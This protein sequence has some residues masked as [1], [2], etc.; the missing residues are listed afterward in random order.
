MEEL[1]KGTSHESL[2][3]WHFGGSFCYQTVRLGKQIPPEHAVSSRS[4]SFVALPLDIDG[5]R[6]IVEALDTWVEGERMEGQNQLSCDFL[7]EID[8]KVQ[9]VDGI[10]RCCIGSLPNTLIFHLKRFALDYTTFQTYKINSYCE[11]PDVL[12][13]GKYTE[14]YLEK[15][16]KQDAIQQ[17]K[18][19]TD[20]KDVAEGDA[21]TDDTDAVDCTYKLRGV[22]IHEGVAGGGHY[23]SLA[24]DPQGNWVKFNDITVTSFKESDLAEETYGGSYEVT[25]QA[26][27]QVGMHHQQPLTETR[28][29][30]RNAYMLYYERVVPVV[31]DVP[32]KDDK[33]DEGEV[34]GEQDED[35]GAAGDS[36]SGEAK[37]KEAETRRS[38]EEE[39]QETSQMLERIMRGLRVASDATVGDNKKLHGLRRW[40]PDVWKE[41]ASIQ[42]KRYLFEMKFFDFLRQLAS[43]SVSTGI[44]DA[45]S[46]QDGPTPSHLTQRPVLASYVWTMLTEVVFRAG[47]AK[48]LNEWSKAVQDLVKGQGDFC[49]RML[50]KMADDRLFV[51]QRLF[52]RGSLSVRN[53]FADVI[54]F[55][56]RQLPERASL[57]CTPLKASATASSFKAADP[58][59]SDDDEDLK[60]LTTLQRYEQDGTGVLPAFLRCLESMQPDVMKNYRIMESYFQIYERLAEPATPWHLRVCT[61]RSNTIASMVHLYLGRSSKDKFLPPLPTWESNVT[62]PQMGSPDKSAILRIVQNLLKSANGEAGTAGRAE[63]RD[64]KTPDPTDEEG[65]ILIPLRSV[66]AFRQRL[67]LEEIIEEDAGSLVDLLSHMIRGEKEMTITALSSLLGACKRTRAAD[68]PV[69][70]RLFVAML[71][72]DDE[73]QTDRLGVV[74]GGE[75]NL[76]GREV[77]GLV[78][79]AAN[80]A[81]LSKNSKRRSTR[82]NYDQIYPHGMSGTGRGLKNASTAYNVLKIIS[83]L[84]KQLP[85]AKAWLQENKKSWVKLVAW[86]NVESYE[87]TLSGSRV[88]MLRQKSTEE[89]LLALAE[90]GGC[91]LEEQKPRL[92]G[93]GVTDR[94]GNATFG[95]QGI[96]HARCG[97]AGYTDTATTVLRAPAAED[98][99][100]LE[101][102]LLMGKT[103]PKS[104]AIKSDNYYLQVYEEVPNDMAANMERG[105]DESAALR[106]APPPGALPIGTRVECAAPHQQQEQ[107]PDGPFRGFVMGSSLGEQ[108]IVYDI[109]YENASSENNVPAFLC[110]AC[111]ETTAIDPLCRAWRLVSSHQIEGVSV[112]AVPCTK[113]AVDIPIKKGQY[114][115]I[116]CTTGCLNL[117]HRKHYPTGEPVFRYMYTRALT[118]TSNQMGHVEYNTK[119]DGRSVWGFATTIRYDS[120]GPMP[121]AT[122]DGA[123]ELDDDDDNNNLSSSPSATTQLASMS[124]LNQGYR[125]LS[126]YDLD[127]DNDDDDDDDDE[128][129][130]MDTHFDEDVYTSIDGMNVNTRYNNNGWESKDHGLD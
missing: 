19:D 73:Y 113:Y 106:P 121:E 23:W 127:D 1:T 57:D 50:A 72:I 51:Y 98:G 55:M 52:C 26:V 64:A 65:R 63:Q 66:T 71:S 105:L 8:G 104:K 24:R 34:N 102:R 40:A 43:K 124:D 108:G 62:Y 90:T 45:T 89:T 68:V 28:E 75:L 60:G 38:R 107:P 17:G 86:L 99:R 110:S 117:Y 129:F 25:R 82:S 85:S 32:P 109:V 31:P 39:E 115:G 67:L 74:L 120:A 35:A 97:D 91:E 46:R 101:V 84:D 16:S 114:V 13:M 4:E 122:S 116:H 78:Q 9:K 29:R 54:S 15:K 14:S 96:V 119:Q 130:G 93:A 18:K 11:F 87:P 103:D 56:I 30:I 95:W 79:I 12:D 2:L 36:G 94:H 77:K 53:S 21:N 81:R 3:K 44:C 69:F 49:A 100:I 48:K 80:K 58:S 76:G 10:R 126:G 83:N 47:K 27:N 20:D 41:N 5:K 33:A 92:E 42:R 111:D 7:P 37:S 88:T 112:K 61:V 125:P 59:D 123:D 128:R 118:A 22:V 6:S 70:T